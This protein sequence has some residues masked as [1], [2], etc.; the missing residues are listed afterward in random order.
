MWHPRF[1]LCAVCRQP[2]R[3]FGWREPERMSRPRPSAW[4]CSITC[5]DFFWQRARR[6]SAM[7]DL[8]DEEKSA[9]RYAMK[10]V[11]EVMEEIGWETRLIDLSEPQVL[12]IIEVVVGGFQDAMREIAAANM[13]PLPEVP[14]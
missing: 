14:F 8:T 3:G 10:M 12:S 11:A 7:V 4:F 2:A 6:S 9:M 5:Q 13:Q 1:A